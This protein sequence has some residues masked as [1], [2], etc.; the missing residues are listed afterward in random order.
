MR[1]LLFAVACMSFCLLRADVVIDKKL[2]AGNIHFHHMDGDVVSLQNE[3]RDTKGWWFYWAFRVTGAEGRKLTFSF[4][5]GDPVGTRGPCVSLDKGKTWAYAA[6]SFTT[7]SFVYSFSAVAKEVWF[8]ECI[9]YTQ[10]EWDEFAARHA[11]DRAFE[12]GVLCKSRHGRTVEKVR[13][14]C[15]GKTPKYRIFITARH[16]CSE[17]TAS[18]VVEGILDAV[19]AKDELGQ[20]FRDNVEVCVVPFVDKDGIEEGDQG[21]NRK[22]HDHEADYKESIYPEPAAVKSWVESF[23]AGK[24]DVVMDVHSPW[25]RGEYNEWAYQVYEKRPEIVAG[26]KRFASL[27]EACQRPGMNYKI[28]NDIPY[29][30]RW[31][32]DKE[33]ENMNGRIFIM[34]AADKLVDVKLCTL[35][36]IP[37]ATANGMV[38]TGDSC[39]RFG[40]DMARALRE[41]LEGK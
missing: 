4:V 17:T 15:L 25:I 38:V 29:G 26:Q 13:G 11:G 2:P 31:N 6:D 10:R 36:E 27:I 40:G 32:N 39:R 5:N 9:P 33:Y 1:F 24:I 23:G 21:K 37:F 7:R 34:W 30:V 8:S 20:W 28:K 16:H 19:L 22:P 14:G 3:F 35:W 12:A 41:Y 18:Y